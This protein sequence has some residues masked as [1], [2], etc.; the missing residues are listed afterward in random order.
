MDGDRAARIHNQHSIDAKETLASRHLAFQ[1][2][3][4]QSTRGQHYAIMTP[5]WSTGASW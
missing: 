1:V 3:A 4:L 2:D 5:H